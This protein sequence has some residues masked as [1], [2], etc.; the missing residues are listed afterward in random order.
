VDEDQDKISPPSKAEIVQA[1][2]KMKDNKT[3]GIDGIPAELLKSDLYVTA[4]ALLILF[5]DI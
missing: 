5:H 1:L 2:R 3:A 4:A